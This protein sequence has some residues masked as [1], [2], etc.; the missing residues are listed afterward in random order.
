MNTDATTDRLAARKLAV[1]KLRVLL[2]ARAERRK[3]N[4]TYF[5]AARN[6]NARAIKLR[7]RIGLR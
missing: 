4:P 1:R 5:P 6:A 7:E 3:L 2:T